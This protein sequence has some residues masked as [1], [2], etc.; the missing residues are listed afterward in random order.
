MQM[1]LGA[2]S[3]SAGRQ[4][5]PEGVDDARSNPCIDTSQVPW[6]PGGAILSRLGGKP[7]FK[8]GGLSATLL[9]DNPSSRLGLELG[10]QY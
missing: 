2:C 10:R 1:N 9:M 4:G 6:D 8:K 7:D 5:N 3:A